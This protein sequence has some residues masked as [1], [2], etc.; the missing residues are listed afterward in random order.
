MIEAFSIKGQQG[1]WSSNYHL[2]NGE[3]TVK[4][5][6]YLMAHWSST[7]L[8]PPPHLGHNSYSSPALLYVPRPPPPL[9]KLRTNCVVQT[10]SLRWETAAVINALAQAL[11]DD[12]DDSMLLRRTKWHPAVL[13]QSSDSS[14][15]F[16]LPLS[17]ARLNV[18]LLSVTEKRGQHFVRQHLTERV[19]RA[20]SVILKRSNTVRIQDKRRGQKIY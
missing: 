14:S 4:D 9:L 2:Q 16:P 12:K 3:M 19:F 13:L 11:L 17:S 18:S 7:A 6:F 10:T 5:H 20:Q 8:P 15:H 1:W